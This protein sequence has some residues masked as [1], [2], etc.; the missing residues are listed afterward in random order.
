MRVPIGR[1]VAALVGLSTA[2]PGVGAQAPGASPAAVGGA[3]LPATLANDSLR[4]ELLGLRR[5]TVPMSQVSLRGYA[6][7]ASL[8]S[9]ACAA[10]LR[11]VGFA[12]ASVRYYA[13]DA[14]P[15]P[16]VGARA[17]EFLVVNVVEPQ[18]SALVR[19]RPAFRDTLAARG[20]WA[21]A[22]A[23]FADQPRAAQQGL[24]RPAT[25]LGDAPLAAADSVLLPARPLRAFL[26]AHR[27]AADRRLALHALASDGNE[28][29]R[30][31]AAMLLANFAADDRAWRALAD[32]L[33]DP[34]PAVR[35]AAMQVLYGLADARARPVDWAPAAGAL[36]AVLDGTNL[37]A[38][39]DLLEALTATRVAPSLAGPLLGGG[40]HLVLAKLGSAGPRE[41]AAARRFLVQ[42]AGRDLGADA[43]PWA[44]WV[45]SLRRPGRPDGV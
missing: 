16:R 35:T 5:W 21:A 14:A 9:H 15:A 24:R 40:G 45:G 27:G 43:E 34:A 38:H 18:D 29:N 22:A 6:P 8:L 4:V 19:Y 32:A 2:P 33:R 23:L 11:R 26:R 42:V 3:V 36:R 28:A 37:F 31:T 1:L 25:F 20:P 10:A 17:Q 39:T 44:R 41:R 12:D 13:P 30:V 7:E